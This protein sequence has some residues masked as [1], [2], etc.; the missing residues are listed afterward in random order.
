MTTVQSSCPTADTLPSITDRLEELAQDTSGKL[1]ESIRSLLSEAASRI[2]FQDEAHV[3]FAA[4]LQSA[5]ASVEQG[6]KLLREEMQR[7]I[8]RGQ[9]VLKL[10]EQVVVLTNSSSAK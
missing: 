1:D 10:R 4:K 8:A 9:E 3:E 2:R 5:C 6:K 7:G